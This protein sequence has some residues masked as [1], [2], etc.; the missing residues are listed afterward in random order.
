MVE[1]SIIDIVIEILQTYG[2]IN[3]LIGFAGTI[4]I[5]AVGIVIVVFFFVVIV[6]FVGIFGNDDNS[7]PK[8]YS[9][10][11]SIWIKGDVQCIETGLWL[12]FLF[13]LLDNDD[14]LFVC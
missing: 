12:M 7:F 2:S 13:Y 4:I 10:L 1:I 9:S 14:S 11:C 5:V 3:I 8:S 6:V